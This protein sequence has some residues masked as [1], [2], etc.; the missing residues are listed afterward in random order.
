M[1]DLRELYQEV[2]LDHGKHPRNFKAI[3][4][5]TSTAHGSN[6]LCGDQLTIYIKLSDN[7]LL[8]DVAFTGRGCAISMASASMLTELAIGKSE[9][10]MNEIFNAF[11]EMCIGSVEASELDEELEKLQVL[12]GVKEFPTRVKC[13][14]LSWHTLIAALSGDIEVTTE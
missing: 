2:I 5:A 13:A 7:G 6:P 8:Q 11:H 10:K 1:D 12:S 14:T 3:E 9:L 4:D